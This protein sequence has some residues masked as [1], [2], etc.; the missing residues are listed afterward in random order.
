M[1]L[2]ATLNPAT[3]P[4]VATVASIPGFIRAVKQ[5]LAD[6]FG[7]PTT[8][9]S[10]PFA[11][12][13]SGIVTLAQ[14]GALLTADPTVALGI[15]TKQYVDAKVAPGGGGYNAVSLG[16]P[17]SLS[18][19]LGAITTIN[20]TAPATG[21]PYRLFVSY[22]LALTAAAGMTVDFQVTDGPHFFGFASFGTPGPPGVS[23][24][25]NAFDFSPATYTAGTVV[26]VTV[27]G[28]LQ[29]GSPAGTIQVNSP[30]G[31]WA[32]FPRAV[33]LPSV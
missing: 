25:V 19:V 12:T 23:L 13:A 9:N 16:A 20:A 7:F 6:A 15:A 3:P 27:Q 18:S 10:A 22:C 28:R 1:A 21:G 33:F 30:S 26:P 14:S 2:P 11:I 24:A 8:L 5:Y 4:D 17:V 32:S 29:V 31:L